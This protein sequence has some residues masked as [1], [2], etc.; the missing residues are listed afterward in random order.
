M[1]VEHRSDGVSRRWVP[2][3][4]DKVG[5]DEK[6]LEDAIAATPELLGLESRRS[7]IYGPFKSITQVDLKTPTGRSIHADVVIFCAS[8]HVV[9]VEVK[10]YVNPELRERAVI[11]Q[12]VDYSS[13]IQSL[14]EPE[15]TQAFSRIAVAHASW[16]SL[17]N[18]WFANEDEAEELAATFLERMANGEVNLVIACDRIPAGLTAVVAGVVAQ[19]SV[20]FDLDLVE[21]TPCHLPDAPDAGLMLLPR[22]RLSTQIV[23]RTVVSVMFQAGSPQPEVVRIETTSADEIAESVRESKSAA[24]EGR[25]YTPMEVEQDF[26]ATGNS[27]GLW[28]LQ[29]AKKYSAGGKYVSEGIKQNAAFGFYLPSSEGKAS[30]MA[31]TVCVDLPRLYWY[32]S[33]IRSMRSPEC[34]SEFIERLK[35]IFGSEI[36]P[37]RGGQYQS[38][39]SIERRRSEFEAIMLWLRDQR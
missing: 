8:G 1:L 37:T 7:G 3:T 18:T 36:D 25:V 38:F 20:G 32:F 19:A 33:Y 4:L 23:N 11:A 13:S 24:R 15:L 17:V 10:R 6:F 9:L 39:D 16:F 31:W 2:T 14:T 35:A 22:N 28:L 26:Q 29:F 30:R 12:I 34:Y 5:R 21:I 27:T